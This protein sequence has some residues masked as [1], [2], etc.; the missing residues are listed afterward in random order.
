MRF[1]PQNSTQPHV[2]SPFATL[3]NIITGSR[4]QDMSIFGSHYSA[5]HKIDLFPCLFQKLEATHMLW[6]MVA[7]QATAGRGLLMLTRPWLSHRL[8]RTFSLHG[9]FPGNPVSSPYFKVCWLATLIPYPIFF[10]QF[11]FCSSMYSNIFTDSGDWDIHILEGP[12][13]CLPFSPKKIL[14]IRGY[15]PTERSIGKE[16][17]K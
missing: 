17:E 3:N 14:K 6:L 13:S 5:Y 8:L 10:F 12:L 15:Q 1:S 16:M 2:Q 9:A 7:S 11:Q 4:D